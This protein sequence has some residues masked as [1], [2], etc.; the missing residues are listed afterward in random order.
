MAANLKAQGLEAFHSHRLTV[1]SLLAAV[2]GHRDLVLIS[3]VGHC[4]SAILVADGVV[5]SLGVRLQGVASDLV[6]AAANQSLAAFHGNTCEAFL[7]NELAVRDLVAILGQCR[8]VIDLRITV[9]RQL[10]R[11]RLDRQLAVLGFHRELCRH[12]VA[13]SIQ[14]LCGAIHF[15][16][17]AVGNIRSGCGCGQAGNGVGIALHGEGGFLQPADALFRAVVDVAAA[18]GFHR[19]LVLGV[20]VSHCQLALGLCDGV[21]RSIRAFVQRVVECV[22]AAAYHCLAAG[23]G[24]GCTLAICPIG[25]L[26]KSGFAVDQC[27]TVVGLAQIGR[28][29]RHRPLGDP[30]RSF[31]P[32]NISKRCCRGAGI[33]V[34]YCFCA[35]YFVNGYAGICLC[36]GHFDIIVQFESN[37][38]CVVP[39]I[40]SYG[41]FCAIIGNGVSRS[42]QCLTVVDLRVARGFYF[43]LFCICL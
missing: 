22:R 17:L 24:V 34:H 41:Q 42:G 32:R 12:I 11:H 38:V 39:A 35:G 21:V 23:E 33:F 2:G 29:Q 8:A 31:N 15:H 10:D 28:L 13:I 7:T 14:N 26:R 25:F 16:C 37:S 36:A 18:V 43:K 3:T 9:R 27:R 5:L 4:Q 30:Q 6:I 40:R 19:D 1:V 20:T